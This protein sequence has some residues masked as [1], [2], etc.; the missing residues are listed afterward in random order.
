[1]YVL[2]LADMFQSFCK[3]CMDYYEIDP[4]HLQT[5]PDLSW[6]ACLKMCDTELEL[7]TDVDMHLFAENG[8]RGGVA[9]ISCKLATVNNPRA[10]NYNKNEPPSY[11]MYLDTNNLYGL[12]VS[13][14]LPCGGFEWA[15]ALQINEAFIL[16]LK[17][18]SNT[19]YFLEVDLD[20]PQ[21]LHTLHN[22]YLFA[23]ERVSVFKIKCC[24]I[25]MQEAY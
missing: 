15:D 18:E 11:V 7:L 1:M 5:S 21:N 4:V 20:Y 3:L 14:C 19:G 25:L 13:Q 23:P 8:M 22:G 12:S 16:N 17:D 9:Q 10:P 24:L 2:L 6:Q